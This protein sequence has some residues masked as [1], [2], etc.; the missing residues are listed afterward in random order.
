M[1]EMDRL[2]KELNAA[3]QKKE[4]ADRAPIVKLELLDALMAEIETTE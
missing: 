3:Y 4:Y 1:S 2:M